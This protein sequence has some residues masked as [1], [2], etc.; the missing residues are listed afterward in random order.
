LAVEPGAEPVPVH[1]AVSAHDDL[2]KA[3]KNLR[4]REKTFP[5]H[6]HF[7]SSDGESHKNCDAVVKESV[8]KWLSAREDL[9]AV[10]W[11]GLQSN[12]ETR[13]GQPFEVSDAIQ[14]LRDLRRKGLETNAREYLVNL[15]PPCRTDAWRAIVAEFDWVSD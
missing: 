3:A 2:V 1:W 4:E 7:V 9:A 10:V 5:E 14:Y 12:W 8:E 11:N 15:P 6:I 13:R